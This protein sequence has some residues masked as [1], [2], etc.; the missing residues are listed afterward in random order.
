M[1]DPSPRLTTVLSDRYTV[2]R[3]IGQGGMAT[4]YLAEDVRHHRKVAIKVLHPELSAV[5]GGDRF[6]NEIELTANLQHPHILPLFDSGSAE[7]LL[8]YV[9]PFIE[10][11]TL[12][13][14]LDRE[15]QLP[16]PD[17]VRIAVDVG[18]ALDY[19]HKRGVVH[20]DIKPENI[21]LHDGRPLVA[22]FGIALAVQ[23]AGGQRMTQTGLSLG[24]P[25]YMSPE[26][27]TGEREIDA[28][29]D[30]YSLGAVTYEMLTGEAPFTG[31]TS[32]AIV[33]KVITTDPGS[34]VARR[35]SIPP[36]VE[37]AVLTALEKVP[38]DRFASA[39]SFAAALSD[40]TAVTQRV[41]RSRQVPRAASRFDWRILA[42][43][44]A[45]ALAIGAVT[46]WLGTRRPAVTREKVAFVHQTDTTHRL[47]T[48][49]C[50][51]A[52]AISPDGRRIVY[53]AASGTNRVL[54]LRT[55]DDVEAHVVS[56]TEFGKNPSFSSD[57]QWILFEH[58]TD[59]T[60][61]V[62]TLRKVPVTGGSAV[63]LTKLGG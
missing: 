27:A 18:D 45:A 62:R 36:H 26:Q 58:G 7:G 31:P 51:P 10:G 46:S 54:M 38:A 15:R 34:L 53:G 42:G 50:S 63:T 37:D 2:L 25:Q 57:G 32:Q 21:L 41:T 35:R 55:I 48:A 23:Q 4:V 11:E 44:A 6:L 61:S 28:R 56:G 39:A 5:L 60:G 24:T 22:E 43:T 52:V 13:A 14:R 40:P 3:E 16:I 29:S 9:M 17:A 20:R 33:A 1:T 8:Y 49:C 47:A 30:I 59:A 19:A 12:R